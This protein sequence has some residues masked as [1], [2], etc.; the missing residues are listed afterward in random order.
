VSWQSVGGVAADVAPASF[1]AVT[2]SGETNL[3]QLINVWT[4]IALGALRAGQVWELDAGGII[5]TSSSAPTLTITSRI[6]V[7]ATPGSNVSLGASTA[8][9]MTA[10]LSSATWFA[11]L[12]FV[13]RSLGIAAS[14]C[15]ITGNGI[16]VFGNIPVGL[17]AAVPT[18][19]D[20]TVASGAILSATWGTSSASNTLTCQWCSLFARS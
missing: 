2:G 19:V 18:T 1:S 9:T 15:T 20:N 5:S 17:G 4:P 10:S 8:V 12:I 3:W 7:S 11:K 13:V 6:G 16:A 14:G